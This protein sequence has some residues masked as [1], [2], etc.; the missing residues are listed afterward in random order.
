MAISK[1]KFSRSGNFGAIFHKNP[2][3]EFALDFVLL[4]SGEIC[5]PINMLITLVTYFTKIAEI[6]RCIF[7]W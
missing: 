2:L 5:P 6:N 3:Y 4:S 7:Y 1:N